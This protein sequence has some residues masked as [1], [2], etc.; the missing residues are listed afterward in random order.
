MK[1]LLIEDDNIK[2]K[3]IIDTL[4][5]LG[6]TDIIHKKA[7]NSGLKTF[8]DVMDT[9]EPFEFVI[10]DNYMPIF[11]DT[12]EC[13]PCATHIV[14]T[15]RRRGFADT[16][17]CVCSSGCIEPCDTNYYLN[18]SA[19]MDLHYDLNIILTEIKSSK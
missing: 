19:A 1:I 2:A 15:I 3:N 7:R 9:D 17:I 13:K 18:Y 6:E 10:T 4:A 14:S 16:P 12:W 8:V 5:Q 11:D